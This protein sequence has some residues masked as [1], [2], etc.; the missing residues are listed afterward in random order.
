MKTSIIYI[1]NTLKNTN[2]I[3]KFFITIVV[4]LFTF[5]INRSTCS[6]IERSN[7]CSKDTIKYKKF[8]CITFK[9]M[10]IVIIL[11]IW[12][13]DSKDLFAFLGIF[14]AALAFAFRDVVGNF[15]GW[16]TIYT[17]KP[18]EMGDR[19]KIGDSLG[20]VLEIGW[21]YTTI[22]EVT[23]NDNKTY[24][25]STGR[26]IS[27][28]NI[29]ILKHELINETNSFPYTWTEINTLISIDSN[30]KKAKKIILSIANNRLGNIEDEAKEALDIASKTLPIN[31]QNLSHTIY[32][33]IENGKIILT[34]RFICRARNFR[35]LLH[36]ITEDILTEFAKHDDINLL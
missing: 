26:L 18:F 16:I 23:T 25:Q 6:L 13:Y 20:D 15:I 3:I 24:G 29:K 19:I 32:T 34:L 2:V 9:I 1:T 35:N 21:F 5:F 11:P 10:C 12:L 22:I 14:S 8:I 30:W 33:A 7:L 36:C 17:Q 31:Y 28:P 4:I 27:V